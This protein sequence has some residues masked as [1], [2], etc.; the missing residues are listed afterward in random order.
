MAAQL[1]Q[2]QNEQKKAAESEERKATVKEARLVNAKEAVEVFK[3]LDKKLG[4][5]EFKK[6]I[7]FQFR[8]CKRTSRHPSLGQ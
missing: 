4:K 5:D 3:K 2:L 1:E 6:I 7:M 8:D